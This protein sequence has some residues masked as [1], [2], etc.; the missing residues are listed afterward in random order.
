M[1]LKP[2]ERENAEKVR[3]LKKVKEIDISSL[4][5][6]SK[7]YINDKYVNITNYFEKYLKDY[8]QINLFTPFRSPVVL[9]V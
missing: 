6:K 5:I 3:S 9:C 4:G 8:S 1:L 7:L 2:L